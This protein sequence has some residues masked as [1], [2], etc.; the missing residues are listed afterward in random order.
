MLE[1]SQRSAIAVDASTQSCKHLRMFCVLAAALRKAVLRVRANARASDRQDGGRDS[2]YALART[3]RAHER[4][5]R[6]KARSTVIKA[7][8]DMR[9]LDRDVRWR[10]KGI[11]RT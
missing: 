11:L 6:D 7:A 8:V 10:M 9:R 1:T 3:H 4:C 2:D 5:R